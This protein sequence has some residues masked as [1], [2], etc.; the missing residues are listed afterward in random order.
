MIKVTELNKNR[1]LT[2]ND[3]LQ[4]LDT[5]NAM[6]A[7]DILIAYNEDHS[8]KEPF[9]ISA[10]RRVLEERPWYTYTKQD[11]KVGI[12]H[13]YGGNSKRKYYYLERVR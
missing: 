6:T 1:S 4:Y 13:G 2:A 11:M 8:E 9:S 10:I 7:E 12:A 3:I 5:E